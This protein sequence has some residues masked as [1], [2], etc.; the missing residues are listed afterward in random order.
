[1]AELRIVFSAEARVDL[2][3]LERFVAAQDGQLRAELIVGRIEGAIRTLAFMPGLG[4][5]R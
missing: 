5:P 4:R 1:M 3:E 2:L